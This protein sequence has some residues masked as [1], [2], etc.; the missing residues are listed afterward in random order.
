MDRSKFPLPFFAW[1]SS[2]IAIERWQESE[3]IKA[4]II[5]LIGEEQAKPIFEEIE[6]AAVQQLRPNSLYI[7]DRLNEELEK[8]V[9]QSLT[10]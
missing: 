4:R 1:N 5:S 6:K 8:A 10:E 3:K 2:K 7:L 9:L